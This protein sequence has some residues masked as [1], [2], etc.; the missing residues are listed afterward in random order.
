MHFW[1]N[2]AFE[3]LR[4]PKVIRFNGIRDGMVYHVGY[5]ESGHILSFLASQ[6]LISDSRLISLLDPFDAHLLGHH[7]LSGFG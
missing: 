1:Q 7:S 6:N 3:S 2:I 4:F 5:K